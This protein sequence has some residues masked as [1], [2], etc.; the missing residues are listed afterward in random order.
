MAGVRGQR[1]VKLVAAERGAVAREPEMVANVAISRHRAGQE[2]FLELGE[3]FLIGLAEDV[4]QHAKSAAMGHAED[5]LAGA[6]IGRL[7]HGRIEKRYERLSAFERK[8]FLAD[9][10]GVQKFF[11]QLGEM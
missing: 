11:K 8:A 9:V 7:L 6:E 4:G 1:K 3:D 5:D 10:A 2:V